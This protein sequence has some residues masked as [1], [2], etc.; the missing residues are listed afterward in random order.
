MNEISFDITMNRVSSAL[1]FCASKKPEDVRAA[2]ERCQRVTHMYSLRALAQLGIVGISSDV[3]KTEIDAPDGDDYSLIYPLSFNDINGLFFRKKVDERY[4]DSSYYS[5]DDFID[6][7]MFGV[8]IFMFDMT[9]IGRDAF[10]ERVTGIHGDF[11][12]QLAMFNR[13][14][15][16]PAIR[17]I[18]TMMVDDGFIDSALIYFKD[19]KYPIER[20]C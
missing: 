1:Q 3:K 8:S 10:Y 9:I 14:F 4:K 7:V 13:K 12:E 19:R 20:S 16:L 15:K 11:V 18:L 2:F 17:L 6:R 5:P